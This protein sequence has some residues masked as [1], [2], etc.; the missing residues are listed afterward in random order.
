M[1][2]LQS[3][4][5]SNLESQI[6]NLRYKLSKAE[7]YI[8]YLEKEIISRD[9]KLEI[10]KVEVSNLKKCLKKALQDIENRNK[11]IIFLETQLIEINNDVYL[12]KDRIQKLRGPMSTST[13][14]DSQASIEELLIQVRDNFKYLADCYRGTELDVL[15]PEELNRLQEQTIG[16][17]IRI[18]IRYNNE[19]TYFRDGIIEKNKN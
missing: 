17:L 12:L 11:D 2:L 14:T 16:K 6:Q 10:F 5:S 9:D 8:L 7:D 15:Q 4:N 19:I 3:N 13:S 18:E 1:S